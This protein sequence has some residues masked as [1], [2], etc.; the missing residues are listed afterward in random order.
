MAA[1]TT[2][3]IVSIVLLSSVMATNESLAD[4]TAKIEKEIPAAAS[5]AQ[6]GAEMGIPIPNAPEMDKNDLSATTLELR[7]ANTACARLA[8]SVDFERKCEF[9]SPDPQNL[10]EQSFSRL[11]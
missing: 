6:G 1:R 7:M 8:H 11:H 2:A 10:K 9:A 5:D 4:S 3:I